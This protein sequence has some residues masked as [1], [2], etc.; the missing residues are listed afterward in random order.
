MNNLAL[1]LLRI[2]FSGAMIYGHGLGKL[3]K[4]ID[5]NLK[6]SDPI[7]IGE[8]PTLYLAV[9]S[10]LIAPIF[11]I[12]GFKTKFFSFFPAATMF[13]AIFIVHLGDPFS[14]IEKAVLFLAV[15]VVLMIN[16]PG[17]YSFD[18]FKS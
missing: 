13:V 8:I 5:G 10:E 3:N 9:F 1:L 15:F 7:G 14:R 2:I 17:K 11:I 12:I 16:G 18:K 6:F 4:I